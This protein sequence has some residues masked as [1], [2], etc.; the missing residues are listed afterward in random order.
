MKLQ[1]LKMP[2][3]NTSLMGVIKG[4]LDYYDI[5]ISNGMAYAGSGHAFLINV[6]EVVCPSG[7]YCWK[8]DTFYKLL[9]NLGLETIDLGF[10]HQGS[11]AD[12]RKK[13]EQALCEYLDADMPGL[14]QNMD[15]QIINGYDH[16]K[17]LLLQ[18]WTQCC[19]TTPAKL[20]FGT[21]DEFGK[22]IHATFLAF[23]K[24]PKKDDAVIIKE[25]LRYA[26]DLFKN[27]DQY[28]L[29]KYRIGS[30]AYDNWIKALEQGKAHAHGNWWNAT[31]WSE[32]R[33]MA[34][35]YFAEIADNHK[36]EISSLSKESSAQY[37][38]IADLLKQISD[39]EMTA[40]KKI[41]LLKQAKAKDEEAIQKIGA[42]LKLLD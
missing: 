7:P 22:E 24:V 38:D 16:E 6:H 3:F 36:D 35:E 1:N 40:E 12:E 19:D 37:K 34:G 33:K 5:K 18:P 28:N 25:S 21:W 30:G 23:K 31:V 8:Y 17:L 42:L 2:P 20:T 15:N 27:P 39:K 26:V 41:P 29:E 13:V 9:Q 10:F 32:C 4:V 14:A 11:T